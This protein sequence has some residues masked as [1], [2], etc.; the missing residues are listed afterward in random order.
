MNPRKVPSCYLITMKKVL[1]FLFF[2]FSVIGCHGSA[3]AAHLT[4]RDFAARPDLRDVSLSPNGRYLALLWNRKK[5]REV[6]IR[7]L[8]AKGA[9]IIG[10]ISENII[11]PNSLYWANDERLII[12]LLVPV[13]AEQLAE[14]AKEREDFDLSIFPKFGRSISV[15]VNAK[16][17]V[18][19]FEDKKQ[20]KG[21]K[22]LS[23][24]ANFLPD[25]PNHVLIPG[26][27]RGKYELY[28]V[29]V[30][31]GKADR[32]ALGSYKTI[33]IIT[34]RVGKPSYRVDY[35]HFDRLLQFYALVNED[36]WEL[37]DQI[38]FD[39]EERGSIDW[40]EL[41]AGY[42]DND[43]NLIYRKKN[44]E[45]GLYEVLRRSAKGLGSETLVSLDDK[46]IHS[47]LF[48]SRS[49]EFAGYSVIEDLVQ[50]VYNDKDK[51]AF[52]N[53]LSKKVGEYNFEFSFP[54]GESGRTVVYV[55][56]MDNQGS[57]H[58]YDSKK[59]QLSFIMDSKI[60]LKTENLSIPA[61]AFYKARDGLKIR[62]YAL[63]P[64]IKKKSK[65]TSE[66]PPL[67]V[68]PHGGPYL[69]D[70]AGYDNFA[71]FLSTRGYVVIQPNFRGS[72]GYG[73]DFEKAGYREWGLKMQDDIT[74]AV[75][76]MIKHKYVDPNRV[77]IVG[78]SY[79]GY[80]ALMGVIKTPNIFKCAVS[81]NGVTH[82]REQIEFDVATSGMYSNTIKELHYKRIGDPEKDREKL[83]QN[84]PILNVKKINK[85]VLIIAGKEDDIV[86]YKQSEQLM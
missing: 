29:N 16:D 49:F 60:K 78:G 14:T 28:K 22:N 51:Q 12:N 71:Q 26:R 11:R 13:R 85:P 10:K 34:N 70:Y 76:Y 1:L 74:D 38:S 64:N 30:Y 41:F 33:S 83:D 50:K 45:T 62:L 86:P 46:N 23:R 82:L 31:S 25:D 3:I 24:V 54:K 7:D 84:S 19:L 18:V 42:I 72:T 20:L 65:K 9:P 57:Y 48:D 35:K 21:N 69:R 37:V 32:V 6:E 17:V 56:G 61:Q 63:F 67:V 40:G 77:C 55:S 73:R 36:E 4:A 68:L 53:K 44:N 58:L 39:P 27:R 66:L 8:D 15:N 47:I 81:M 59:D 43:G 5:F 79:G 52:Y 80:A 2:T 75:R